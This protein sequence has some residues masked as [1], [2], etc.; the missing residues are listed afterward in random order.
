MSVGVVWRGMS[1]GGWAA[2]LWQFLRSS[3]YGPMHVPLLCARGKA[4]RCFGW[5]G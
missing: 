4:L 2:L 3:G 1:G 5:V